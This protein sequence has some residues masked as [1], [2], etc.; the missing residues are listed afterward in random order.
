MSELKWISWRTGRNFTPWWHAT[1]DSNITL[2]GQ[3]AQ[4][5]KNLRAT[6]PSPDQQC[7]VCRRE[8]FKRLER[9]NGV[10]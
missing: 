5:L 8:T 6:D 7:V 2:C 1:E 3:H 9:I 10:P 4:G